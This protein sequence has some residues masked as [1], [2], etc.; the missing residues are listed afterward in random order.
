[1][2]ISATFAAA[3]GA[4][5]M[6]GDPAFAGSGAF[7]ASTDADRRAFVGLRAGTLGVGVEGGYRINDY[8]QVRTHAAGLVYSDDQTVADIASD[9]SLRLASVGVGVDVFP[10]RRVFFLTAG[11]RY[12]FNRAVYNAQPASDY[13]IGDNIYPAAEVG[14]LSGEARFA[15]NAWFAGA[16]VA[17]RPWNGPIEVSLEAGVY[18]QGAP[19]ISYD[20]TGLLANDPAF[21]ADLELQVE[22]AQRDLDK[23]DSFPLIAF[24]LRYRF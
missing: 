7:T 22:R 16:G 6:Q 10:F 8:L 3:F 14:L 17:G 9:F 21:L 13:Q 23:Y 5:S 19:S 18:R 24:N 20:V 12:N 2:S 11:A 1:M 15:P 4:A